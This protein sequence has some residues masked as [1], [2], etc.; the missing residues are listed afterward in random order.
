MPAQT[1]GVNKEKTKCSL[2]TQTRL[3]SASNKAGTTV[4][5]LEA[6]WAIHSLAAVREASR[7]EPEA[8]LERRWQRERF[9]ESLRKGEDGTKIFQINSS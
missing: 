7:S 9:C 2:R 4:R 5:A 8:L 3:G 1:D 6:S